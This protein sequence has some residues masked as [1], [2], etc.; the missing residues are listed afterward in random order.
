MLI[1]SCLL[2]IFFV[3]YENKLISN[4]RHCG[5]RG[6]FLL[7]FSHLIS[8]PFPTV[9]NRKGGIFQVSWGQEKF[10]WKLVLGKFPSYSLFFEISRCSS[11]FS[12]IFGCYMLN[13][14]VRAKLI[15]NLLISLLSSDVDIPLSITHF[16]RF[17]WK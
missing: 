7:P 16:F 11:I 6:N 10:I 17:L 3:S 12:C 14:C 5:L 13:V 1:F 8:T 15:F 4:Q 9:D 2:H